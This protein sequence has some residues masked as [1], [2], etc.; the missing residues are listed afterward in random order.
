MD[1][2][3]AVGRSAHICQKPKQLSLRGNRYVSWRTPSGQV[4]FIPDACKHRGASLSL[5]TVEPDGC[6]KCAYH[7]WR[8]DD[9]GYNTFGDDLRIP[10]MDHKFLRAQ[11][12][13]GL[14]W[15]TTG[16][17]TEPPKATCDDSVWI[18]HWY[19]QCAQLVFESWVMNITKSAITMPY[20][21]RFKPS[22]MIS[23]CPIDENTSKMFIGF[24]R[25]DG[26]PMWLFDILNGNREIIKSIDKDFCYKGLVEPAIQDYRA[27]LTTYEFR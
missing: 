2:W 26:V 6:L 14:L 25:K 12:Q 19:D 27:L 22:I 4:R 3:I 17:S 18:E 21:V 11:E 8:Y 16:M 7:K 20:T 15:V 5:G 13:D 1:G 23:V 9:K 10:F 24:S